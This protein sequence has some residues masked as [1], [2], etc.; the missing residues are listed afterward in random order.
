MPYSKIFIFLF[1]ISLLITIS[2]PN[3]LVE[4]FNSFNNELLIILEPV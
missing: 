3:P 4:I 2:R 1:A